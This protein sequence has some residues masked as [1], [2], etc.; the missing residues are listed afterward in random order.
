MK[1][2]RTVSL[3]WVFLLFR[4]R[5][6]YPAELLCFSLRMIHKRNIHIRN[7][8][9]R[10]VTAFSPFGMGKYFYGQGWTG[11]GACCSSGIYG[12][13]LGKY[14]PMCVLVQCGYEAAIPALN[15]GDYCTRILVSAVFSR[16]GLKIYPDRSSIRRK[17]IMYK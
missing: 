1:A 12:S 6:G 10:Q 16:S 7:R 2:A 14:M 11:K 9:L 15:V 3:C 17:S 4:E 5:I 13:S 8:F